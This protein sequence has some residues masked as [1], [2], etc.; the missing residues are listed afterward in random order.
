VKLDWSVRMSDSF[1]RQYPIVS[2]MPQQMRNC[3]N[4]E[5]G[6]MLS[7]LE[8]VWR[9]TGDSRYYEYIKNNVDL[10]IQ[11]DGSITTYRLEDYNVDQINQGKIL[12]LLLEQSGEEKYRKSIELLVKQMISH[13]RTSEGGLW[14]KNIYPFQ[15]WL[16]GVYMTSPFLT[17]YAR[18]FH[19]YEWYD[20]VTHEIILMEKQTRDPSTGLLYHAW[21]ESRKQR[22]ADQET[23]CSP[24]FWSRALGWYVM[25]IVDVLDDLP[26]DY[27]KRAQ[28][29]HIFS[30]LV[31]AIVSVQDADSG[32]WYQVIDQGNRAGNYLEASG[33]SM[34]VYAIAKG[35]RKGY[36]SEDYVQVAKK[37]FEGLLTHCVE[38][39]ADGTLHL[40]RICS[41]AGLGGTP[42]RDGS[43]EYYISEPVRRDDPKGFAPFV[44][45]C[46]EMEENNKYSE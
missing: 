28:I 11:P 8:Q 24:H 37:G 42:Y 2:R 6:C 16:D 40:G 25:A 22:W 9:K 41:V 38:R 12:F 13:P 10:Y 26:N 39:D 14:H 17:R 46:L 15:M 45:A 18:T 43:F 3:W 20:D 1:I 34:F 35:A 32:L 21:D 4:Y 44:M 33:S 31:S 19:A 5:D 36:I 23:G 7:A 29:I 30:Q 27:P